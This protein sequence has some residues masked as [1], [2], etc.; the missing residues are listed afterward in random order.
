MIGRTRI[1]SATVIGLAGMTL[2]A[3]AEKSSSPRRIVGADAKA[4]LSLIER[5]GC[6]ACHHV[7]GLR[8][9]KGSVGGSLDGFALQATIAGRFPNRPE[10]LVRWLRDAPAMAPDTAMPASGLTEAEARDVAAYL[11]ERDAR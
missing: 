5:E 9:P 3:C 4:G 8:W 1:A 2:L 10:M 11:Y 6:A 7:P